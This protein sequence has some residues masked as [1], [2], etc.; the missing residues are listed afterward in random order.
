MLK[1]LVSKIL[2]NKDLEEVGV[3]SHFR[4]FFTENMQL[5]SLHEETIYIQKVNGAKVEATYQYHSMDKE[6][7][8]TPTTLSF[9]TRYELV[10]EEKEQGPISIVENQ[11]N[12][13]IRVAF[14]TVSAP[15]ANIP[16]APSEIKV[17]VTETEV[18]VLFT[19]N[20]QETRASIYKKDTH[21]S[22]RVWPTDKEWETLTTT[23]FS[24]PHTF[25]PGTYVLNLQGKE[26]LEG[27]IYESTIIE[28]PFVIEPDKP[29]EETQPESPVSPLPTFNLSVLKTYPTDNGVL[30]GNRYV[31]LFSEAIDV[32]ALQINDIQVFDEN[33]DP[34]LAEILGIQTY[35]YVL[36]QTEI[37]EESTGEEEV[38]QGIQILD[39][40]IDEG[41]I[42]PDLNPSE[43]NLLETPTLH[44][45]IFPPSNYV[46]LRFDEPLTP[47]KKFKV[48]LSKKI[49]PVG[50][51]Q[52]SLPKTTTFTFRQKWAHYYTDVEVV[53]VLLGFFSSLFTSD[54]TIS[55][56]IAEVSNQMYQLLKGRKDFDEEAWENG[57]IPFFAL[58]FVK[59][60]VAYLLVLNQIVAQSTGKEESVKL[61]DLSVTDK[62][63]S[64]TELADLL[65]LLK[66]EMKKWEDMLLKEPFAFA[67]M[68]TTLRAST[69]EKGATYPDYFARVP[70]SALGG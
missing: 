68:K 40:T 1:N 46:T 26:T 37:K 33:E 66:E 18:Q 3:Q 39:D 12:K 31:V 59:Y 23:S 34:L 48:V 8:V 49:H 28:T 29:E 19:T 24:L 47:G 43:D 27:Q 51:P 14:Q 5:D 54:E 58:E 63:A 16:K 15:E 11:Q 62:G 50:R 32:N 10:I 35:P 21:Q 70:F 4:L 6:L 7:T 53:R 64:T 22:F 36:E 13:K 52:V 25:L 57:E 41:L 45:I 67:K 60:K 38:E 56:L 44:P 69:S 30:I 17:S 9:N 42:S 55:L 61:G 20:T 65:A 2:P